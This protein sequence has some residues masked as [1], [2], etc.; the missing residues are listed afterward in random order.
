M[1][2]IL[3]ALVAFLCFSCSTADAALKFFWRSETTTL[4]GTD[5]YS[6]GD[7]TATSS[8]SPSVSATAS[9][10]SGN[11]V[12]ADSS[13]DAY[14]FDPTS[15]VDPNKGALAYWV[16]FPTALNSVCT[17][18][19]FYQSSAGTLRVSR[20][21]GSGQLYLD[22]RKSGG[23]TYFLTTT[24]TTISAGNSYFI[25]AEWDINTTYRRIRVYDSGL[26]LIASATDS[27]TD[28]STGIGTYNNIYVGDADYGGQT[29]YVDNVFIGSE[30]TDGDTFLT[31]ASITS[32]TS[33]SVGS[34]LMVNPIS[35][36]G[37]T[38]AQP[39]IH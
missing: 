33:Y 31:N 35:G 28:F 12:L 4:S 29:M 23:G 30:A 3:C 24:G 18:V 39:V 19:E 21:S 37:G 22:I 5:D 38:A 1:K 20:N 36:R 6:A 2:K 27:A 11:G 25:I 15:I 34:P 14:A 7:T 10:V 32:Y 8:N 17:G 26:T 16:K 9:I 13:G